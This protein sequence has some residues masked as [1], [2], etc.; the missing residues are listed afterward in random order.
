M[1]LTEPRLAI[2]TDSHAIAVCHTSAFSSGGPR[3]VYNLIF[4]GCSH[5]A[6]VKLETDVIERSFEPGSR[7]RFVVMRDE[8]TG[9]IVSYAQWTIPVSDE[10][11][12]EVTE[13][14]EQ[15]KPTA[16]SP[17]LP[18]GIN[19]PLFQRMFL[20]KGAS[21]AEKQAES[22]LPQ[23]QCWSKLPS[24]SSHK[25]ESEDILSRS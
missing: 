9:E 13:N 4:S 11:E 24:Y 23:D 6:M 18:A 7:S 21:E 3:T 20:R 22:Q 8:D 17:D 2:P 15:E 16:K 10:Q 1:P 25:I 19:F 14:T 12:G 5:E